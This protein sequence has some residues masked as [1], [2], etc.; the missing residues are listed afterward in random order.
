MDVITVTHEIFVI[1]VPVVRDAAV[2]RLH[3]PLVCL[4][5]LLGTVKTNETEEE[6]DYQHGNHA[7]TDAETVHMEFDQVKPL[8]GFVNMV[9][10]LMLRVR[11]SVRLHSGIIAVMMVN[12]F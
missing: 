11:E 8:G 1:S 3:A 6:K 10:L 2:P 12:V 5:L 4:K 9:L 7:R